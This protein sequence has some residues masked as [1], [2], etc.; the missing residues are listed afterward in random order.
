VAP[1]RVRRA[2]GTVTALVVRAMKAKTRRHYLQIDD[3]VFL[4][5]AFMTLPASA[6]KLWIDMRTQFRGY[7]NG[8][9]TVAMSVLL[10]RGWKSPDTLYRALKELLARGLIDRTRLGKPGPYRICSLFRFT[11][12]ATAENEA[13]FIKG[14]PPTYEFLA[15][16][17]ESKREKKR[18]TETVVVPLR[19]SKRYNYGN[20]SV[21]PPTATENVARKNGEVGRQ[22]A[23]V[24]D[25]GA[26]GT[27]DAQRYGNRS[28]L[29]LPGDG[30][31]DRD[32]GGSVVGVAV[33]LNSTPVLS[34]RPADEFDRAEIRYQHQRARRARAAAKR[35]K[36]G[37]P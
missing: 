29:Y 24:L 30:G 15:W 6:L 33:D 18:A 13:L 8:N 9:I 5:A 26:I 4:S 16:K 23:P 27:N 36:R 37:E 2:A 12:L 34:A 25:S 17:G 28:A 22:A 20:R 14:K 7:N 19:K 35:V 31:P 21:H 11:D 32:N 10:H 1:A 3:T